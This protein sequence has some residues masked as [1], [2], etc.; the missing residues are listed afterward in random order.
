MHQK[1][2]KIMEYFEDKKS[3]LRSNKQTILQN[4]TETLRYK[5]HDKFDI[6]KKNTIKKQQIKK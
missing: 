1:N 6:W 4:P 3:F 5:R 2:I